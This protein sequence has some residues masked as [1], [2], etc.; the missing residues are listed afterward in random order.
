MDPRTAYLRCHELQYSDYTSVQGLL[1]TMKDYQRKAP[2]QL[3][4]DNLISILWNKV[5]YKLQKEVGEINDWS[6]QEL[7]Q[8][9]LRA[10][11][12]VEEHERRANQPVLRR[13]RAQADD[14]DNQATRTLIARTPANT[15]KE[16]SRQASARGN[17]ELELKN[18]KCFGCHKKGHVVSECPDKKNKELPRMIQA[19]CTTHSTS[20]G[21]TATDPWIRILTAPKEDDTE[22]NHL[23]KLVGPMYKVDVEV[24][25]VNI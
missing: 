15:D 2:E 9:L 18:V 11:S 14:G 3:S 22:D 25:G 5:P 24:E 17:G 19:E 23:A 6:L 4:N 21:A 16:M 13:R 8:R 20:T 10:E 1:E 12:R 7:L